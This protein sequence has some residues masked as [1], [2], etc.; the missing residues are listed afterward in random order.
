MVA[1][2]RLDLLKQW[3]QQ[4]IPET[5]QDIQAAS[6]DA[7]FRRYYRVYLQNK[8]YIVMDAPPQQ[9]DIRPFIRIAERF[10]SIGLQVPEIFRQDLDQGFLL[11]SDLGDEI[12]LKHLNASNAT[13]LYTDAIQALIVLQRNSL[14][15]P[16]FLP[17]YDAN[18]LR[19]ELELFREWF[20]SKHLRIRL[21]EVQNSALN[22]V[23]DE[24]IQSALSQPRVW[25]HRD[26]HSR[27]LMCTE[28]ANPA[29]LD[30]QDAVS[31]PVTT[32]PE[33]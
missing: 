30:F 8:T 31:G 17:D 21:T 15:E 16:H 14:S 12:Y 19:K 32:S 1:E 23:F 24:L 4:V 7:S 22:Q 33:Q 10:L 20:L 2:Q 27:N 26:Y 18:L 5:I 28:Q 3:L 29:I 11:L 6:V 9:E 13:R 25:V